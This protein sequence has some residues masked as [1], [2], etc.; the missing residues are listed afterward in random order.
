MLE[1]MNES[2][3]HKSED[4]FRNERHDI[5][6]GASPYGDAIPPLALHGEARDLRRGGANCSEADL[7]RRVASDAAHARH[8]R[9]ALEGALDHGT[10]LLAALGLPRL[11]EHGSVP[12]EPR[13]GLE[14]GGGPAARPGRCRESSRCHCVQPDRRS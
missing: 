10:A 1:E 3:A 6:A 14:C 7:P 5:S 13:R 8:M 12:L 2:V 11:V 9:R 4:Y